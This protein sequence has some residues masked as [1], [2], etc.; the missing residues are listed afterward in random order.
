MPLMFT[1][2]YITNALI[3]AGFKEMSSDELKDSYLAPPDDALEDV[4]ISD[5]F[6]SK[7]YKY[8]FGMLKI[9]NMISKNI[10]MKG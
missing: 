3:A 1:L 9:G 2:V 8:P 4:N 10:L 7:K 5:D 6:L